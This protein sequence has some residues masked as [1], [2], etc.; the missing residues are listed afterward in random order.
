MQTRWFMVQLVSLVWKDC[1]GGNP[2]MNEMMLDQVGRASAVRHHADAVGAFEAILEHICWMILIEQTLSS[3]SCLN[4]FISKLEFTRKRG[5]WDSSIQNQNLS[6]ICYVCLCL[7]KATQLT[8]KQNSRLAE[9]SSKDLCPKQNYISNM[10]AYFFPVGICAPN[11]QK[12][13]NLTQ[14][15]SALDIGIF[16]VS[17]G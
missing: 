16:S 4:S 11:F 1:L 5:G 6:G 8:V 17:G 10:L 3:N 9:W 7:K 2:G 13:A 15:G 12:V 14:I